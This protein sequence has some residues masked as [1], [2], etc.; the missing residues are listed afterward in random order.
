MHFQF[1]FVENQLVTKK[2][3]ALSFENL[4]TFKNGYALGVP[5]KSAYPTKKVHI[6]GY[7][8]HCFSS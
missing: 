5:G 7:K 2:T 3:C 6:Q 8:V 4:C 1:F